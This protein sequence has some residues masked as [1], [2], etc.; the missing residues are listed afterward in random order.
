MRSVTSAKDILDW[1]NENAGAD[2][3]WDREADTYP[4]AIRP[5]PEAPKGVLYGTKPQCLWK[6]LPD[7]APGYSTY[8]K[9]APTPQ[10]LADL[11]AGDPAVRERVIFVGDLDPLDL[12]T[13]ATLIER[14]KLDPECVYFAGPVDPWLDALTDEHRQIIS[15]AMSDFEVQLWT[16]VRRLEIDWETFLGVNA[17]AILDSGHKIELDGAMNPEIYGEAFTRWA[18][19]RILQAWAAEIPG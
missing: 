15:V 4:A 14:A 19:A 8:T 13:L 17:L 12:L 9:Y 11:V 5:W 1:A 6:M 2:D 18:G 10:W 3:D 7:L 16:H